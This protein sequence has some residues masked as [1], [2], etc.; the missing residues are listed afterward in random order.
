M[1]ASVVGGQ[2]NSACR[3]GSLYSFECSLLLVSYCTASLHYLHLLDSRLQDVAL[4]RSF[5]IPPLKCFRF[6]HAHARNRA[7]FHWLQNAATCGF[8]TNSLHRC[9]GKPTAH[10]NN[11]APELGGALRPSVS[12]VQHYGT[13]QINSTAETFR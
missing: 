12:S 4:T 11:L 1:R 2:K 8:H 13:L 3:R 6:R 9:C 5:S 7:Q 10:C